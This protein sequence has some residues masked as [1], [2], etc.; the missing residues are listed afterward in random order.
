MRTNFSLPNFV[1]SNIMVRNFACMEIVRTSFNFSFDQ[2]H[3]DKSLRKKWNLVTSLINF[4]WTSICAIVCYLLVFGC[5]EYYSRGVAI[6]TSLSQRIVSDHWLQLQQSVEGTMSQ[7]IQL[8]RL[9]IQYYVYFM[10]LNYILIGLV[11]IVSRVRYPKRKLDKVR[12]N[13]VTFV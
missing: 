12:Q 6:V 9:Y 1:Q 13:S 7:I 10:V 2:I 3:I 4:L 8:T 11:D 5:N